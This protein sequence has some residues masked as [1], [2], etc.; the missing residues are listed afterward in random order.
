M[1][2]DSGTQLHIFP[3]SGAGNMSCSRTLHSPL[4]WH[5]LC[6]PETVHMS[7]QKAG[8]QTYPN[9]KS[10]ISPIKKCSQPV[11]SISDDLSSNED[12]HVPR[13]LPGALKGLPLCGQPVPNSQRE[14]I[15]RAHSSA[16]PL[17]CLPRLGKA[18][19]QQTHGCI[20]L[21]CCT[22][23]ISYIQ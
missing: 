21:T 3:L 20:R 6:R 18:L 23:T 8:S 19:D 5:L 14:P 4:P 11:R 16:L 10:R 1:T 22:S 13:Q 12:D 2:S 17:K 15:T 9:H 7:R